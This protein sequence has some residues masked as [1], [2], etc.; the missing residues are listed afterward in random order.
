MYPVIKLTLL[1]H[2]LFHMSTLHHL[3]LPEASSALE[4][5]DVAIKKHFD[6]TRQQVQ[7]KW[8]VSSTK[9]CSNSSIE[10]KLNKDVNDTPSIIDQLLRQ[11]RIVHE[12]SGKIQ[13]LT[14][15]CL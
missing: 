10:W 9:P 4:F 5:P 12:H 3:G 8:N 13:A 1:Y 7:F 11:Y 14:K 15:S 2:Y 6:V